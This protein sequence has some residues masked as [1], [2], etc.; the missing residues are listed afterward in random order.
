MREINMK[1]IICR[2]PF[3][4][5]FFFK[6]VLENALLDVD[7]SCETRSQEQRNYAIC[8]WVKPFTV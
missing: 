4:C 2:L 7:S 1:S 3:F 5:C 6:A 8:R